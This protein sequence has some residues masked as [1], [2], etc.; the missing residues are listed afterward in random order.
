MQI[1]S[2]LIVAA[3]LSGVV[4]I[5]AAAA[6]PPPAAPPPGAQISASLEYV[7]RVPGTSQ[8]VEGKFDKVRGREVL[9]ITGRFGFKTLD[10]SNPRSPQ[11]LDTFLPAEI[12]ARTATGRTRTWT[13]TRAGS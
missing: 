12:L 10:V 6:P 7:A 9:I 4:G 1:R 13:S 11:V 5:G 3:V 8:V 2:V